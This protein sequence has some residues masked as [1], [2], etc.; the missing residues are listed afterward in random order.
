VR[1]RTDP[2]GQVDFLELLPPVLGAADDRSSSL[3]AWEERRTRR[4]LDQQIGDRVPVGELEDLQVLRRGVSGRVAELRI[5][6]S[7]GSTVVKGFDVRRVLGLRES[8][9]VI[10]PQRDEGG[11]LEAVVFAGRGWGHG[12]GLCQVGAYGMALRGQ[13]Y[14]EI[15]AHYYPGATLA[16]DRGN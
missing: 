16:R 11:R 14:R 7:A 13:S 6:G 8:L 10:E 2:S 5:V 1:F 12:V 9:T 4:Q 15:L 3:F